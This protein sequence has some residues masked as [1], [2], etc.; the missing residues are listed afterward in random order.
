MKKLKKITFGL[1]IIVLLLLIVLIFLLVK[2]YDVGSW[3]GSLLFLVA[4]PCILFNLII[5]LSDMKK[6]I[7]MDRGRTIFTIVIR[8]IGYFI[9]LTLFSYFPFK[10]IDIKVSLVSSL[11]MGIFFYKP[12]RSNDFR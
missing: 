4:L 3:F 1:D 7:K 11:V 2:D 5:S 6:D 8:I 12:I 10:R 9:L